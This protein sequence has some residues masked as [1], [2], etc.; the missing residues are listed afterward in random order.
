MDAQFSVIDHQ[1]GF[2]VSFSIRHSHDQAPPLEKHQA[3][4]Y[5]WA[6]KDLQLLD[7]LESHAEGAHAPQAVGPG[8]E[9]SLYFS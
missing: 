1:L 4:A 9:Q 7:L 8:L 3:G 5:A 6:P 2:A